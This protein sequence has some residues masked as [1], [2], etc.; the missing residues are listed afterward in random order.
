MSN[1]PVTGVLDA[2][3]L[4]DVA[5]EMTQK[6]L[7]QDGVAGE[8]DWYRVVVHVE[9]GQF[10]KVLVHRVGEVDQQV[11]AAIDGQRH[12]FAMGLPGR[13]DCAVD[14]GGAGQ[15]NGRVRLAGGRVDVSM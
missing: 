9:T 3:G 4:V 11:A 6:P 13:G 1:E 15:R 2:V 10:V 5:G 7:Q 14:L 8:R 12:P